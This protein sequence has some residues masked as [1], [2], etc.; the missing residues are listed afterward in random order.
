MHDLPA[1][2][3]LPERPVLGT[4]WQEQGTSEIRETGTSVTTVG[5]AERTCE[6]YRKVTDARYPAIP[7]SPAFPRSDDDSGHAKG[8]P[9]VH[10]IIPPERLHPELFIPAATVLGLLLGSFYNGCIHRYLTGESILF[11]PTHYPH[12]KR[13][14][15]I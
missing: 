8:R 10:P 3:W 6:R 4:S 9:R 14:H 7:F 1:R 11:P 15:R 5:D 12:N 13:R 2:F